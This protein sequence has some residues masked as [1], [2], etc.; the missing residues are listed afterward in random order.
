MNN[1][2]FNGGM[3]FTPYGQQWFKRL[4]AGISQ[5]QPAALMLGVYDWEDRLF[6]RIQQPLYQ[7]PI[8]QGSQLLE[9]VSTEFKECAVIDESGQTLA[10]S[11][12]DVAI[13]NKAG[14]VESLRFNVIWQ[15][16]AG[17]Q[18]AAN[19][20]QSLNW[21]DSV[22]Q[23]S[24]VGTD[25]DLLALIDSVDTTTASD[26]PGLGDQEWSTEFSTRKVEPFNEGETV[27]PETIERTPDTEISAPL[28]IAVRQLN[29]TRAGWRIP[30]QRLNV[31]LS[32]GLYLHIYKHTRLF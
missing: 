13:Q 27:P 2:Q 15:A 14:M 3:I 11:P 28:G 4:I 20:S 6:Q 25:P 23:R 26:L 8:N 12:L 22:F 16:S 18:A 29:N 17:N 7:M 9:H 31:S 5:P 21:S 32:P 30:K 24:P 19:E 1:Y 10:V